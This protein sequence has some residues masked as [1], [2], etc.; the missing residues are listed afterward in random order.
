MHFRLDVAPAWAL[1]G[2][3]L[4]APHHGGVF[5]SAEALSTLYG[6]DKAANPNLTPSADFDQTIRRGTAASLNKRGVYLINTP[7][8][9]VV[10][11]DNWLSRMPEENPDGETFLENGY[12]VE[13]MT[14][15]SAQQKAEE[16]EHQRF[17]E[18]GVVP[19][20]PAELFRL[21]SRRTFIN[22]F[23]CDVKD[24]LVAHRSDFNVSQLKDGFFIP[25]P[26]RDQSLSFGDLNDDWRFF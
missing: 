12:I 16:A 5:A 19:V 20:S 3:T 6:M 18:K 24:Y 14:P 2:V 9:F 23:P 8:Y 25:A 13:A 21:I 7:L 4:S 11:R 10:P 1:P 15:L 17:S 26:N 22:E